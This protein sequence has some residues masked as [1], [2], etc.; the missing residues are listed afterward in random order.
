M[1]QASRDLLAELEASFQVSQRALLARDVVGLEACT[2][3]QIRLRESLGILWSRA[4]APA[5]GSDRAHSDL[6]LAAELRSAQM[7][8]LHLGRI[9]GA[10]LARAQRW[11]RMVSN[12]LAGPEGSYA[13]S[14]GTQVVPGYGRRPA[15]GD[16]P[17]KDEERS[18][19]RA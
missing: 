14:A 15:R 3:E 16:N 7:R 19:C 18:P 17:G 2:R 4:A 12:L 1:V 5:P 10:L 6:G 13:L 8:V 9:Q 11:L